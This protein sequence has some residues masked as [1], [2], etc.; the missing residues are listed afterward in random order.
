[1]DVLGRFS[2]RLDLPI[3][4]FASSRKEGYGR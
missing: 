1:V 3:A 4:G 2:F